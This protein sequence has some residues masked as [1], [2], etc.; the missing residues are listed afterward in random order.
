MDL[1]ELRTLYAYNRW[2]N[3]R[4][5]DAVSRLTSEQVH[6]P[7]GGSF[8]SL[9]ATLTH[10]LGAEWV[11]LERFR[12]RSPH[13]F[14]GA[15]ALQRVGDV[16][17]RWL[18]VERDHGTLV[19]SLTAATLEAAVS[20]TNFKGDGFTQPLSALLRHVV[21]HASYHRGQVT[22]ML[23]LL[24]AEAVSTDLVVFLRERS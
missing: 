6:H 24:G 11:W 14:D 22:L 16:R 4:M 13:R 21:N 10:M 2:A 9:F 7:L 23:R 17:A 19:A 20:Y 1:D 15:D 5:L 3:A 8:G 18:A 12:G